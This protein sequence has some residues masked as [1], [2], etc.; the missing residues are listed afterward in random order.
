[1]KKINSV[2][3]LMLMLA[4]FGINVLLN[5]QVGQVLWEE[6]FNTLNP[7]FWNTDIGDGCD[8]GIC[9][10][11]NGELQYYNSDNLSIGSIPGE[12]GSSALI[13]ETRNEAMGT[14]SFTSGRI[15]SKFNLA[16][17][18]GMVEIRMSVPEVGVGLWPA[19]WML[20]TAT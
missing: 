6:N 17:Q 15:N 1:M 16:I 19:A 4:I 18:Y 9:G 11:G 10:W 14:K 8:Q 20:G 5:A 13:I 12:S 3:Q 7:E 2:K